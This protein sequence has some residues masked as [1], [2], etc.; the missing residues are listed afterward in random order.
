[1]MKLPTLSSITPFIAPSQR[2]LWGAAGVLALCFWAVFTVQ[3]A[4]V[5]GIV[6]GSPSP[7]SV[8]APR[9]VT[10]VSDVL[11]AQAQES[12]AAD[13]DLIQA[14]ID[15]YLLLNQRVQ[16][17]NLLDNIEKIR[18]NGE[19]WKNRMQMIEAIDTTLDVDLISRPIAQQLTDLSVADWEKLRTQILVI[20]DRSLNDVGNR[21]DVR[22]MQLLTESIIPSYI[23]N[24]PSD[25]GALISRFITPFIQI[26]VAVDK[27][28]TQQAQIAARAKVAPVTVA[29]Q[30]GE[31]IVRAG[32]VVTPVILEKL[33]AL[34][35]LSLRVTW[36]EILGQI[37]MAGVLA[38][39]FAASLWHV[40]RNAATRATELWALVILMVV[41]VILTRIGAGVAPML[42]VAS[43]LVM[44]ALL[45]STFYGLRS[46][47]LV[48]ITVGF[49]VFLIGKGSLALGLPPFMAAIVGSI[50][51][52]RVDRS[53]AFVVAGCVAMLTSMV[54]ALGVLLMIER[55]TD[56]N[57]IWPL[58]AI[59]GGG[60]LLSAL[61]ALSLCGIFGTLAGMV[62]GLQLLELAHPA[63]PLLQR[64][65]REAPGT[66]YHS[67]AVG[68]LAESAAEAI[69]ADGLLLRVASYYHDIGKVE[70]PFYFTDN[71]SDGVNLHD[72]LPPHKSAQIIIDHVRN[73]IV[74]ARTARLPVKLI[75]FIATH[76]GTSVVRYFYHKALEADASTDIADFTYPG[77]IPTSREQVIMML[78][79]S[80]EAT[81]RSKVQSGAVA[82]KIGDG[83]TIDA[84]VTSIID[85]R[86]QNGQLADAQVTLHDIT[87]IREAFI[88]T[89]KG[90][91]HPRVDYSPAKKIV[92]EPVVE[93]QGHI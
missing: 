14:S 89:L 37:L 77:P 64:L 43:P 83:Q 4:S 50:M 39:V 15:P 67:V 62:S 41:A 75:D 25:R 88:T 70:H 61:L 47:L 69:N 12:A 26:N 2:L 60:A 28:R 52:R 81:V 19:S 13:P 23:S 3:P 65:V 31:N 68:N 8:Q 66:Y 59:S 73:G 33:T 80:V 34:G 22:S 76:H 11:T 9:Q 93:P 63:Q 35:V 78:A 32:D 36:Y 91:Y 82:S 87:R 57:A 18:T 44:A 6:V 21:I 38:V 45:V 53:L 1:M 86:M 48:T 24:T 79:D 42:V 92:G 46:A 30:Q 16:L 56:W 72:S 10:F 7:V 71:Q 85:E 17:V 49:A 40:D 5:Q 51:T 54:T 84:L 27:A 74:M 90:I 20:Y 58:L 55:Q 29:I